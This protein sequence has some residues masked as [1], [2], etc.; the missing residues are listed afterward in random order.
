MSKAIL[1]IGPSG[2]GKT[3][4]IRTLNPASTFIVNSLKK[5]LPWRGSSKQYTYWNKE[6]NPMGN[7]IS[8]TQSKIVFQWLDYINNNFLHIKDVVI[9][10]N[11]FLTAMELQRRSGETDW[12]KFNDI[13]QNFLD[14]AEKAKS[15]RDDLVVHILHHTMQ[16]GG[17]GILEEKTF[18]AMS[19]G[20]LIDEK[21]GSQEAQFTVVLRAAKEADGDDINYVFYTRD[22]RS[23]VKTPFGMFEDAKIPNDMLLV[24]K[25]V[26]CYYNDDCGDQPKVEAKKVKEKV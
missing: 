22:A 13:A 18:R 8:T 17:D 9:D 15:L 11:T 7:M 24:R 1:Y 25:A 4:S 5:D 21:L 6:T 12:K 2:A 23:S 10:D 26:D 19:Y 3:A 14:L 20:K 16:D